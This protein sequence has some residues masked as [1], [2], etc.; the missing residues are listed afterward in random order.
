MRYTEKRGWKESRF[1]KIFQDFRIQE[2]V[3]ESI[4]IFVYRGRNVRR[5]RLESVKIFVY[6]IEDEAKEGRSGLGER[7]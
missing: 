5:K 3:L 7:R 1:S 2:E 6:R 4:K